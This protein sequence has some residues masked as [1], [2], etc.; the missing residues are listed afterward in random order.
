MAPPLP[1][2]PTPITLEHKIFSGTF[3]ESERE[4]GVSGSPLAT[5][6]CCRR[7]RA[8]LSLEANPS[9]SDVKKRTPFWTAHIFELLA[10]LFQ[11]WTVAGTLDE[12]IFELLGH[13]ER[14]VELH[15][16][17]STISSPQ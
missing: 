13:F 9:N 8:L 10:S 7:E 2:P 3:T 16:Q 14:L 1:Q 11:C 6:V 12:T 15:R 17:T 4:L 5:G